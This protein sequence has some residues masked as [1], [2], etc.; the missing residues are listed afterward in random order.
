M[1]SKALE[2]SMRKDS[3]CIYP[4]S[5]FCH[6]P[7][8][9]EHA[10]NLTVRPAKMHM[11]WPPAGIYPRLLCVKASHGTM[12]L[13]WGNHPCR[14]QSFASLAGLKLNSCLAP[15][16]VSVDSIL[17][18]RLVDAELDPDFENPPYHV[19]NLLLYAQD[20]RLPGSEE[21]AFSKS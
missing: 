16:E 13:G 7:T 1:G 9:Y 15:I 10:L 12:V 21:A 8:R 18:A 2:L 17:H 14:S 20:E 4:M 3:L 19:S 5:S 11:S 6:G